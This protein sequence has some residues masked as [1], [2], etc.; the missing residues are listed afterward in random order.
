VEGAAVPA[1]DALALRGLIARRLGGRRQAV[2]RATPESDAGLLLSVVTA[3]QGT[4]LETLRFE[5]GK[6][7]ADVSGSLA[8]RRQVDEWLTLLVDE[9]RPLL[10]FSSGEAPGSAAEL[11][12]TPGDPGSERELAAWLAPRC[13]DKIC[14]IQ[15][16]LSAGSR[17]DRFAPALDALRRAGARLVGLGVVLHDEKPPSV[18]KGAAGVSG[19]IPP[20]VIQRIVRQNFDEFRKCYEGGLAR[21]PELSGRVVA[22]FVIGRDGRV[23]QVSDEGSELADAGVRDCVLAAFAGLVFPAPEGGIVTVVYPI[24][25]APEP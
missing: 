5:C 16:R 24:M 12:F 3:A 4:W 11:A 17:I 1:A 7:Y 20:E 25:L 14:R 23:S 22:R 18:G 6:L 2:V 13:E 15:G 10:S 9:Q 21:D 8:D 19:R